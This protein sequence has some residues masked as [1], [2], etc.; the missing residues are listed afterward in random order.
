MNAAVGVAVDLRW[1]FCVWVCLWLLCSCGCGGVGISDDATGLDGSCDAN[2]DSLKEGDEHHSCGCGALAREP[3]VGDVAHVLG[4]GSLVDSD[5]WK[6]E[7]EE[8]ASLL[9]INGGEF[10]MGSNEGFFPEDGEGPTRKVRISSFKIGAFEVSNERFKHF[11]EETGYVT[12]AEKFGNSFVVEQFISEE[13]SA[14][15]ESAVAAAPWWLPVDGSDWRHPEGPDSNL[16]ARWNHPVMHVSWNDAV[17]F[18]KWSQPQ[19]RLPTEAE[20]EYAASGGLKN[21]MFP[22]GNKF[23]PGDEHAM[24]TWQ[25]AMEIPVD[26]NVFKHSFLPT[27]EGHAFYMAE[28]TAEDGYKL[29]APV[30]AYKPNKFGLYNTAGN[31]W[32]WTNDWHTRDFHDMYAPDDKDDSGV[33]V[34][35]QGPKKGTDKVK[36]GGSFMCHQFTCYRYRIAARMP[37]TPDSSAANVGFRCAAN[38]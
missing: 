33:I 26:R 35:P 24:N 5:D 37:L 27:H 21:R 9:F 20:W 10:I 25:S 8:E 13:V 14:K 7:T 16:T 1:W 12:E 30:N 29:T 34:N 3:I 17:A 36:K 15:I 28:N 6:G 38:A 11:V 22:W 31:V 4:D 19:G 2:G 32:E 23:M 18:C